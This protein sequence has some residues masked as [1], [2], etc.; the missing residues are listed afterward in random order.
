M[1]KFLYY[2]NKLIQQWGAGYVAIMCT[3]LFLAVMQI[4]IIFAVFISPYQ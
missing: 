1:K 4:I 3:V 2:F